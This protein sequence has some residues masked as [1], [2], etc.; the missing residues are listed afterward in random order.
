MAAQ[1]DET[2]AIPPLKHTNPDHKALK[3]V[4]APFLD[5]K[6]FTHWTPRQGK[7]KILKVPDTPT[8]QLDDH[9]T[10]NQLKPNRPIG[11]VTSHRH[12]IIALDIDGVNPDDCQPLNDLLHDHPTYEEDSPSGLPHRRRALYKLMTTEEK[13]KLNDKTV[14]N[15]AGNELS[16]RFGTELSLYC[17]SNK[18]R[19]VTLTGKNHNSE[20]INL[21]SPEDLTRY[22]PHFKSTRMM[23][24]LPGGK[25]IPRMHTSNHSAKNTKPDVWIQQVPLTESSY[26]VQ[27][28][29]AKEGWTYYEY[30]LTGLMCLH[31]TFGSTEGFRFADEWSKKDDQYYD[32][33]ELAAKWPT[34]EEDVMVKHVTTGTFEWFFNQFNIDWPVRAS[35]GGPVHDE[36]SNFQ[37][38]LDHYQMTVCVD[39]ITKT[40][41]LEGPDEVLY[42]HFYKSKK[43]SHRIHDSDLQR[44]A[45][46][47][48]ELTR[49]HK[50][51]PKPNAIREHLGTIASMVQSYQYQ[52]R[53]AKE[54]DAQ[55]PYDPDTEDDYIA[56]ISNQIVERDLRKANPTQEL[57]NA[58]IRKW[59][60]SLGRN[61]WPE[62]MPKE[63]KGHRMEG[64]LL[65]YSREGGIGKSSF[66]E[67]IFPPEW[68]HLHVQVKPRLSGSNEDKD[69]K[70]KT[71]SSL[72]V[73][74]D[75][76]E[77]IFKSNMDAD[78]K[79]ALTAKETITRFPYD[80]DVRRYPINYSYFASTNEDRVTIPRH[81]ARRYWWTNI[82]SI[83]LNTMDEL[84]RYRLWAQIKF[85]VINANKDKRAPWLLTDGERIQLEKTI[86]PHRA[87]NKMEILLSETYDWS[88]EGYAFL[89]TLGPKD[90]AVTSNNPFVRHITLGLKEIAADLGLPAADSALKRAVLPFVEKHAPEEFYALRTLIRG[91]VHDFRGQ[92][93]Y[94]MPAKR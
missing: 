1:H 77:R 16:P 13:A 64:I 17:G 38:L 28:L 92:K 3:A 84:D 75:E 8:D 31:Y 18:S 76:A 56:L 23:A 52:A 12:P 37:A 72:I 79:S 62:E 35:T 53:L 24:A 54:V 30:W 50:Y 78:M 86:D 44:L 70:M 9:L 61:L 63:H 47:F 5:D 6:I 74:F 81:G 66:A 40:V 25:G 22:F 65:M 36:I 10:F 11:L 82:R 71:C 59:L 39:K 27:R 94:L 80:T 19:F 26:E 89:S 33:D 90:F 73:D 41:Y 69:Y 85:E 43:A 57:H 55:A 4:F 45:A 46:L 15:E 42:P 7:K 58:M 83:D 2:V 93:R 60:I 14:K 48:I 91:G 32:Y 67:K 51:R 20:T 34:L 87:E 29:I 88:P 49:K 21:I 68:A